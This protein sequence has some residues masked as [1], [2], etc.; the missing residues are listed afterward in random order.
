MQ[1]WLPLIMART[2]FFKSS[3]SDFRASS[4]EGR[5]TGLSSLRIW[6]SIW[7]FMSWKRTKIGRLI[8]VENP[9][10]WT[11]SAALL[12]GTCQRISSSNA[13][14]FCCTKWGMMIWT[15]PWL[16]TFCWKWNVSECS[17]LSLS[18]VYFVETWLW[19]YCLNMINLTCVL[20]L[21]LSLSL[22][23]NSR[24]KRENR[25]SHGI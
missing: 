9:L 23:L 11:K 4:P 1:S 3:S 2:C 13:Q 5:L 15:H 18:S 14:C 12:Q 16:A 7:N 25:I 8:S 22:W 19:T 17:P 21:L 24:F 10:I 20:S 6:E